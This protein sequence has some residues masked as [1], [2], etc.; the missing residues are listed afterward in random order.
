V[1]PD[2][3]LTHPSHPHSDCPA[4]LLAS[5]YPLILLH[6]HSHRGAIASTKGSLQRS[7]FIFFSWE[8]VMLPDY[9]HGRIVLPDYL[10]THPGTAPTHPSILLHLRCLLKDFVGIASTKG[11]LQG[12]I[13]FFFSWERVMLPDYPHECI[14][15]PDYLLTHPATRTATAYPFAILLHP[16]SLSW[17]HRVDQ[18]VLARQHF[19]DFLM[20]AGFPAA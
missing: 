14:V 8:R 13:L 17:G 11:S 9:P 5:T 12:S 18:R 3:L 2:C 15:L 4:H 6:P 19:C 20:G 16:H 1:L 10:L 7:I